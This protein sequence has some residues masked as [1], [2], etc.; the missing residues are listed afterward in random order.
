MSGP[1]RRSHGS[2]EALVAKERYRVHR[3]TPAADAAEVTDRGNAE[4]WALARESEAPVR[5][6]LEDLLVVDTG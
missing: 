1:S 3:S 2:V 6:N 4:V 5:S